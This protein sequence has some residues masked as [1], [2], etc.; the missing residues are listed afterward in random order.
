[1]RLRGP[2]ELNW[3]PGLVVAKAPGTE[4]VCLKALSSRRNGVASLGGT[5]RVGGLWLVV[6]F[7]GSTLFDC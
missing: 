7:E 3:L 4:V 5:G 1:M 6:G 2:A